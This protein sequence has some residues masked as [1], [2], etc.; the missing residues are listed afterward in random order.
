MFQ[1]RSL[2]KSVRKEDLSAVVTVAGIVAGSVETAEVMA[3]AA[4][5]T[6]EVIADPVREA[7]VEVTTSIDR[8]TWVF[9]GHPDRQIQKII[10]FMR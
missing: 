8:L 10:Y 5:V 4:E 6:A 9:T 7:I 1:L 2:V 3:E